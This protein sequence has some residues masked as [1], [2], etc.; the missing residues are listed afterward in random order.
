[1]PS[2]RVPALVFER[3]ASGAAAAPHTFRAEN[4]EKTAD[5]GEKSQKMP[6]MGH[7]RD[8]KCKKGHFWTF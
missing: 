1:M 2:D 6:K 7:F 3:S 5:F 8:L 4:V